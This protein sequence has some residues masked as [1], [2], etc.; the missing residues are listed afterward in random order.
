MVK[1]KTLGKYMLIQSI[2]IALGSII[3]F[4]FM[5]LSVGVYITWFSLSMLI[6]S[7]FILFSS[8]ALYTA[9]RYIKNKPFKKNKFLGYVLIA[10][11]MAFF[12]NKLITVI[13]DNITGMNP[14]AWFQPVIG[15]VI[16]SYLLVFGLGFLI[17]KE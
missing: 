13:F 5:I 10:A 15:L 3:F 17:E 12:L 9:V 16:G 14:G 2:L 11:G 1:P 6:A 8:F 7:G 4:V